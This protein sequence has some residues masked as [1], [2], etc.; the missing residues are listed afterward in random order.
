MT[1]LK[2]MSA[3]PS[4]IVLRAPLP[5]TD[6]MGRAER[7]VAAALIVRTCHVHGDKWQP[8]TPRMI[9]E[10]IKQDLDDGT[11]P[12]KTMNL[13][14]FARPDFRDLIKAGYG[15]GGGEG[16]QPIALTEKGLLAIQKWARP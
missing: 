7:E 13:Y 1:E 2:N 11:E 16:G 8:V 4:Q 9:G 14:P 5:L 6:T 12:F 10:V 3:L 15:E